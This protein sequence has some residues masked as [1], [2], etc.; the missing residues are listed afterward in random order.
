MKYSPWFKSA[1]PMKDRPGLYLWRGA[2]YFHWWDGKCW[3]E[4]EGGSVMW[5]QRPEWCGLAE[6]QQEKMK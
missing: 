3:R 1:S 6:P 5:C 4:Y 2:G